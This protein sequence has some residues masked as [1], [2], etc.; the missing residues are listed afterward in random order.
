MNDRDLVGYAD[1]PPRV[2]WPNGARVVVSLVVNYE[3]GS[4]N[5]LQDGVGRRESWGDAMSPVPPDRRDLAN[6]S[7]FEY[8]SR[9]GVWRFFR[10]FAKYGVRSTFF[11]C[12]VALERNPAVAHAI[13]AQGHDV[14]GHG[15]RWEEYYLMD[16]ETER[17]AIAEGYAGIERLTFVRKG[18]GTE[19]H[20]G[21]K[22]LNADS[23][24]CVASWLANHVDED[25][26]RRG[27]CFATTV[28][29]AGVATNMVTGSC[30]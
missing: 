9:A 11:A 21:N 20:K 1:N 28:D 4:E 19:D 29:D 13:T 7:M 15:N 17:R 12:A 3:E 25:A 24:T 6:E 10:I 30:P 18:R 27:G 16:R 2:A 23:D 14:C 8:G 26:C 5:L 22:R